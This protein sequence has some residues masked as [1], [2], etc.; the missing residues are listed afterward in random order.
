MRQDGEQ[1][2]KVRYRCAKLHGVLDWF[3]RC[4]RGERLVSAQHQII[5]YEDAKVLLQVQYVVATAASLS[6]TMH[7]SRCLRI[8][9][10][11]LELT[12]PPVAHT[13][14]VLY[15]NSQVHN[16]WPLCP[17][18]SWQQHGCCACKRPA[19]ANSTNILSGPASQYCTL[20]T[21]LAA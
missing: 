15:I 21:P 9:H 19:V 8:L 16:V 18:A 1:R 11:T 6:A 10:C 13:F 3:W 14:A 17:L 12:G 5:G 20:Q 7:S 2:H 4:V